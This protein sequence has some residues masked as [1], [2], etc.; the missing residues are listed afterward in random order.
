MRKLVLR[1]FKGRKRELRISIIMLALIYMCGIMTILFQGSFY[2][3]L[4]SLRYETYGEW[5]G[6][7][8][9]AGESTEQI[10]RE[11]ESTKQIGKIVVLG[12]AWLGGNPL[13]VMGAADET[14]RSLG[15]IQMEEG[16]F[17]S[18]STEIALTET[19]LSRLAG[20]AEVG[21]KVEIAPAENGEAKSYTLS[22]IVKPWG[23]EWETDKHKL[24]SVIQAWMR[25]YRERRTCYSRM[26]TRM[27]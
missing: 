5:T 8:F 19:A 16:H 20:Q 3:S 1:S 25:P 4:E 21:G 26:I 11:L 27:R 18:D 22:G 17:P 7:V 14:A 13:G 9:G 10:L 24:P 2:R 12:D 6:A 15:R 23:R